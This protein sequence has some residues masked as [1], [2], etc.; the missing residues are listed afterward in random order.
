MST[1]QNTKR[2]SVNLT[3]RD[4][5]PIKNFLFPIPPHYHTIRWSSVD[6]PTG[7]GGFR[8]YHT[9][10]QHWMR[11]SSSLNYLIGIHKVQQL[12]FLYSS[13]RPLSNQVTTSSENP[14]KA[15]SLDT[16][17]SSTDSHA[18]SQTIVKQVSSTQAPDKNFFAKIG[19]SLI[20]AGKATVSFIAKIPGVLWFYITHSK[21]RHEK[22]IEI[23]DA[24][25]KEAH[26][27][28]MGTKVT[29]YI[30]C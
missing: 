8:S 17:V 10:T 14:S 23:K 29:L 1:N 15:Q 16:K 4:K 28:W 2:F 20:G 11:P 6:I 25:K 18:K 5:Y 22:W 9:Q 26:H 12:P 13:L 30:L 21:E 27:Y 3:R 7:L 24:A 19:D